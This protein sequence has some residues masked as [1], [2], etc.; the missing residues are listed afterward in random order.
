MC[1]LG[2]HDAPDKPKR[3]HLSGMVEAVAETPR[4][5][6]KHRKNELHDALRAEIDGEPVDEFAVYE[7]YELIPRDQQQLP[8]H[9][10]DAARE[11]PPGVWWIEKD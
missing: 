2:H 1:S 3:R 4:A 5:V 7:Q 8:D 11:P 9:L 6:L 10:V